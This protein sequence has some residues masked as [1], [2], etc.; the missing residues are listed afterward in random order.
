[1]VLDTAPFFAPLELEIRTSFL[2]AL[3][4]I[5]L[6]KIDGEYRQLL[7]HG[8]KQGGLAIR[9]PVDTA[10]SIHSASLVATRHLTVSLV[11][12]GARFDLGAHCH[13]A[14]KAGQAGRKAQ[15]N[16]EQLFLDR[17]SQDNPSVARC[18]WYMALCL[19]KSV[20]W[21]RPVGARVEG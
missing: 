13:C 3:L 14:T 15:L 21:Y 12:V 17:C 8:V 6:T 16:A 10:P 11:G 19:P 5:L 4:G 9:N 1:M 20:E 7:T 2:P 18:R